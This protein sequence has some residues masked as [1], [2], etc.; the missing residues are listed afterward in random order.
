MLFSG[1][2]SSFVMT[3]RRVN[4]LFGENA[5]FWLWNL[6][7]HLE[8]IEPESVITIRIFYYK[9]LKVSLKLNPKTPPWNRRAKTVKAFDIIRRSS[10]DPRNHNS[11]RTQSIFL[12]MINFRDMLLQWKAFHRNIPTAYTLAAQNKFSNK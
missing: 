9:S 10:C 7:V 2:T 3:R 8:T 5:S 12:L 11:P 4:S 1:I 6:S